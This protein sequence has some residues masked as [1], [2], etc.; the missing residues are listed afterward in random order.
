M[1]GMMPRA[2]EFFWTVWSDFDPVVCR[3]TTRRL[4]GLHRHCRVREGPRDH[5]LP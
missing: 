1:I 5:S 2:A 3:A 4:V